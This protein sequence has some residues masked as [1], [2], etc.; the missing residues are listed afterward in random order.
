MNSV[1]LSAIQVAPGGLAEAVH[2]AGHS[3]GAAIPASALALATGALKAMFGQRPG[4]F[5]EEEPW[6]WSARWSRWRPGSPASTGTSRMRRSNRQPCLWVKSG[7]VS[8]ALAKPLRNHE[9]LTFN[10]AKIRS[11]S[12]TFRGRFSSVPIL[13]AFSHGMMLSM[14]VKWDS[15]LP[16]TLSPSC[17]QLRSF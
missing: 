11:G 4:W 13:A 5:W 17:P 8:L 15:S 7:G 9:V 6:P 16:M 10:A 12:A 2:G 3:S 14:N 1:S